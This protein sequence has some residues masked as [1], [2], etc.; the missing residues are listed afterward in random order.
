MQDMPANGK[1][2][3][4]PDSDP[5]VKFDSKNLSKYSDSEI[6]SAVKAYELWKQNGEF[7]LQ[8]TVCAEIAGSEKETDLFNAYNALCRE[9][10]K[11]SYLNR[12]I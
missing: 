3:V 8:Y 9:I 4:L 1:F 6:I 5:Q 11:R 7:R 12:S 10:A 2:I